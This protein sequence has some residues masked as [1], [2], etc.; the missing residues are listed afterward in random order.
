M[1]DLGLQNIHQ[2]SKE[3]Q[4][5]NR[6]AVEPSARKV[7]KVVLSFNAKHTLQNTRETLF[8]TSLKLFTFLVIAS[9]QQMAVLLNMN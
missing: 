6:V 8:W 9:H 3:K 7:S 1:Y 5:D 2:P 4:E